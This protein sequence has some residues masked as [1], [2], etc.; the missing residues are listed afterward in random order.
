MLVR[1]PPTDGSSHAS[2][3]SASSSRGTN[4]GGSSSSSSS[5]GAAAPSIASGIAAAAT[6]DARARVMIEARERLRAIP[7]NK[8]HRSVERESDQIIKR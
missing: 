5:I 3:G 7:T 1:T 4:V 8:V 2:A 6:G